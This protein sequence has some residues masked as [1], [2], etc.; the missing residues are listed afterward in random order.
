MRRALGIIAEA[1]GL[2]LLLALA[3]LFA[4]LCMAAS[5]YGWA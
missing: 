5:D 1:A 2:L 3:A 4:A